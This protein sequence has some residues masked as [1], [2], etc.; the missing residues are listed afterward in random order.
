M[1]YKHEILLIG[2][3]WLWMPLNSY[4]NLVLM[5]KG[6]GWIKRM[7]LRLETGKRVEEEV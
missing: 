4:M 3:S 1:R 5:E 7:I 6:E 2:L